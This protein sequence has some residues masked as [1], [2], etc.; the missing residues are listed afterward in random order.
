MYVC[1]MSIDYKSIYL[2]VITEQQ[3]IVQINLQ[4]YQRF[5]DNCLMFCK[6]NIVCENKGLLIDIPEQLIKYCIGNQNIQI[7]FNKIKELFKNSKHFVNIKNVNSNTYLYFTMFDFSD[8]KQ[9]RSYHYRLF[10]LNNDQNI[11]DQLVQQF[12]DRCKDLTGFCG[13]IDDIYVVA[14]NEN[15]LYKDNI[16]QNIYH[17]LSHYIQQICKIRILTNIKTD[18]KSDSNLVSLSDLIYY[19]SDVEFAVHVDQLT[20][21]LFNTYLNFYKDKN[22]VVYLFDVVVNSLKSNNI[23]HEQF[24]QNYLISNNNDF[25]SLAMFIGS[26]QNNYKF[27]KILHVVKNNLIRLIKQ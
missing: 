10:N 7:S 9:I 26:Y 18:F 25:S 19:F 1:K 2:N 14:V 8:Q 11:L 20:I 27:Q 12:N 15:I 23:E 21:S 24:F 22:I 17:E 13:L 3:G 4:K 5:L 16:L 6:E